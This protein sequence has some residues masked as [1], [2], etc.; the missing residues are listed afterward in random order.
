MVVEN[1][2]GQPQ[3]YGAGV[4]CLGAAAKF[5]YPRT[6]FVVQPQA[7]DGSAVACPRSAPHALNGYFGSQSAA[8]LGKALL[9]DNGLDRTHKRE[10][11]VADV[12]SSAHEPVGLFGGAICT[13][14]NTRLLSGDGMVAAGMHDSLY[15]KCSH[16]TPVAVSAFAF[17]KN[18]HDR[19]TV[20]IDGI[21]NI[22]HSKA[23][24]GVRS[25]TDHPV[26]YTAGTVCVS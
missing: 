10:Y 14:L 24:V 12:K 20:V 7:Y 2:S 16:G 9:A 17:P 19:G 25:L 4:I 15:G 23:F 18:A 6:T 22:G 3:A 1:L 8:D 5:A 26:A 21:G 13:S 11:G